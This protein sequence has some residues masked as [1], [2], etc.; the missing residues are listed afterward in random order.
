MARANGSALHSHTV[1]VWAALARDRR[2]LAR[3]ITAA[4]TATTSR[5]MVFVSHAN[6]EDNEFTE[7]LSLRLAREGYPVWCDLT[8][9][10]G[11]ETFWEDIEV[12]LRDRTVKFLFVLSR[13]SN[14]KAGAR[15][16]LDL[17][18]GLERKNKNNKAFKDFVIPL[19]VD[20]LP[21]DEINIQLRRKGAIDFS[22]GWAGG[23][24][25]LLKK[26]AEDGVG[27]DQRFGA[28]AVTEWWHRARAGEDL[29]KATPESHVSNWFPVG[30]LPEALYLHELKGP[31][32]GGSAWTLKQPAHRV[33]D[34]IVSFAPSSDLGGLVARSTQLLT[35]HALDP[36][37]GG[38]PLPY[39][40]RRNSVIRILR[41]AWDRAV[42]QRGMPL[43]DLAR[44]RAAAYFLPSMFTTPLDPI[45]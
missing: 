33:G 3:G 1:P 11:G 32:D 5:N 8:K 23:F 40:E 26:L 14:E 4:A 36:H 7:W 44:S 42:K 2:A 21:F 45:A 24:T 39:R 15:N 20:D 35:T 10:L 34:Y 38:L 29:V 30:K 27:R 19:R 18:L 16:E 31:L 43:Y 13:S 25:Q 17:A 41:L 12:A 28:E 37:A 9:L 6:P 22:K